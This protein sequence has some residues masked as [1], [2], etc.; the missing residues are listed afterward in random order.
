MQTCEKN[1]RQNYNFK[2]ISVNCTL[3]KTSKLLFKLTTDLQ[4]Q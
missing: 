1:K 4:L 3:I 2:K